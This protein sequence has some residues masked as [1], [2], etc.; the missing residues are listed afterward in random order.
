MSQE[1]VWE[2]DVHSRLQNSKLSRKSVQTLASEAH[3]L[4]V[5]DATVRSG[6]RRRGVA[7][8]GG[9]VMGSSLFRGTYPD[10]CKCCSP[11]G[12]APSRHSFWR[13]QRH[14]VRHEVRHLFVG[15]IRNLRAPRAGQG[16][17][18]SKPRRQCTSFCEDNAMVTM[19]R[20]N[21]ILSLCH[22]DS[23]GKVA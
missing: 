22:P 11:I 2:R 9:R 15:D 14:E 16:E 1:L 7:P 4:T 23:L 12:Y 20:T 5:V 17:N 13:R 19:K 18:G 10:R 21:R 6:T 3:I 8:G